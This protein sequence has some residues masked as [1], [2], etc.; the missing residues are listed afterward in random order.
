MNT[1]L[2]LC[3]QGDKVRIVRITGSGLFK[4]R[5]SEMG[6]RK[7]TELEV[8]KYAPLKDPVELRICD[9]F[10][11]LRVE[12]AERIEVVK[13]DKDRLLKCPA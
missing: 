5:L 3:K 6:F 11:S 9:Y 12:E 10:V 8:V 1:K 7:D 4:H 13:L 2:S